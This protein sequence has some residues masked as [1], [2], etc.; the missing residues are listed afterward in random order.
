[1][2]AQHVPLNPTIFRK[3]S[4][5]PVTECNFVITNAG[6][7]DYIGY[8]TAIEWVAKTH[9]QVAGRVYCGDFFVPIVENVLK[10]YPHWKVR[11]KKELTADKVKK[12]HTYAPHGEFPNRLGMHSVDLGFIY[13]ANMTAPEDAYYPQL[14]L[15]PFQYF[16]AQIPVPQEYVVMTPYSTTV[17]RTMAPRAFNGIKEWLIAKGITPVFLGKK[18]ITEHRHVE[19]DKNYDFE[20]GIDLTGKTT[21]LQAAGV[22][23]YAKAVVGLDNGLLHLAAMTEVPIVFGYTVSSPQHAK[24]RRESGNIF[25]IHPNKADL[26]CTFCMSEMRFHFNHNYAACPYGDTVCIEV[27]SYPEDWIGQIELAMNAK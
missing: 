19:L 20:G 24:P 4:K 9:P 23:Q 22:M 11:L 5:G 15:S 13:Y 25:N 17:P 8:L 21:L 26:P 14:D 27:L 2:P 3:P 16:V 10:K 6:I 7:G 18:E 12:G 1:M